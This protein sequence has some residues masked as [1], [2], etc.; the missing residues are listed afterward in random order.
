MRQCLFVDF[1]S[2]F[3]VNRDKSTL[4]YESKEK[5]LTP[6]GRKYLNK[7]KSQTLKEHVVL[8]DKKM[9]VER[10]QTVNIFVHVI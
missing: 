4:S 3:S 5:V 1:R 6:K 2:A 7:T 10:N 9:S 8:V